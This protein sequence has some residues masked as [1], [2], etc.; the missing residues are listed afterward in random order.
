[1]ALR[2]AATATRSAAE[3]A[4]QRVVSERRWRVWSNLTTFVAI[5]VV[6]VLLS[7]AL[8][9]HQSIDSCYRRLSYTSAD[10]QKRLARGEVAPFTLPLPS[11]PESTAAALPDLGRRSATDDP[12]PREH[13][14]YNTFYA[15]QQAGSGDVGVCCCKAPHDLFLRS[16]GRH[17][18]VFDGQ[19]Y[20]LRWLAESEFRRAAP[21]LE[22]R[23]PATW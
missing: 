9:D 23:V 1:M 14:Y 17:V 13:Y 10:L 2:T 19:H 15:R 16:D 11:S 6:M 4:T 12:T 5:S 22:L 7:M 21:G 8:R 18:L 3:R 20:A